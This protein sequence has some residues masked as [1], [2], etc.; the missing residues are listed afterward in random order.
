MFLMYPN[1][2]LVVVVLPAL[3]PYPC[4]GALLPLMHAW[5]L[6]ALWVHRVPI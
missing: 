4:M 2:P 6:S 5:H 3:R 1:G